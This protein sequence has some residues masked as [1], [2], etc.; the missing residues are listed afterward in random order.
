MQ[1]SKKHIANNK[2]K[3]K[4]RNVHVTIEILLWLDLETTMCTCLCLYCVSFD[5]NKYY[6]NKIILIKISVQFALKM[7]P[8]L[9]SDP[10]F[11]EVPHLKGIQPPSPPPPT[12]LTP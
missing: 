3:N 6:C 11:F 7:A 12:P 4:S 10:V 1:E 2:N 9:F 8:L 5:T